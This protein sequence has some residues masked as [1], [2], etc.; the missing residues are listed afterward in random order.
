M[1]K[2]TKCAAALL[3]LF[4]GAI[5]LVGCVSGHSFAPLV[6]NPNP[7]AAG[8]LNLVFIV[9]ED[10]AFNTA[11]DIDPA[12]ANLTNSGLERAL[13]MDTFLVSVCVTVAKRYQHLCSGADDAL[14][15]GGETA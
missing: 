11:G 3:F 15:N 10:M 13:M 14:A 4:F 9:S 12:T 8:N 5:F 7:P 1:S 6:G 2:L